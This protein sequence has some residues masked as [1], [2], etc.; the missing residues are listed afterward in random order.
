[1]ALATLTEPER[2][3]VRQCLACVASEEIIANDWEF[4]TLFGITFADLQRVAAQWPNV[5]ES[6]E[7]VRLAINN[8]MNNLLGYPHGGT[9][10]WSRFISV[11]PAE[12]LRLFCKW[13]G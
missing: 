1:M 5:D 11:P 6:D 9:A 13:R 2:E 10:K 7:V 8:S 12:V 4:P 3:I